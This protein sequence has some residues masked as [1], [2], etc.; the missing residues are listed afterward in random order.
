MTA[1]LATTADL[2]T[3]LGIDT[4]DT[5]QDAALQLLID[6]VEGQ[7]LAEAKRM[8]RPFS[9]AQSGRVEVRAGT[10]TTNLWLDY[11]IDTVTGIAVG[12][13]PTSTIAIDPADGT[14]VSWQAGTSVITL[15]NGDVWGKRDDPALVRVTYNTLADLPSHAKLA[16]LYASTV[17]YRQFGSEDAKSER[18]A[19]YERELAP[20]MRGNSIWESA[21][22]TLRVRTFV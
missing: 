17:L 21:I 9:T 15:V 20:A 16:V 10:G 5:S 11:D 1:V 14:I 6:L 8:H 4:G 13:N 2:K 7:L 12:R 19:A 18:V 22:E 3:Y